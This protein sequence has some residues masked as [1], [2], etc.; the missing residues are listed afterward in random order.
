MVYLIF[1][2]LSLNYFIHFHRSYP[3]CAHL[4]S[5]HSTN[6]FAFMGRN[7]QPVGNGVYVLPMWPLRFTTYPQNLTNVELYI[8]VLSNVITLTIILTQKF[9]SIVQPIWNAFK[10]FQHI[11]MS[12]IVHINEVLYANFIISYFYFIDFRIEIIEQ[13][14]KCTYV[15]MRLWQHDFTT[16]KKKK[17]HFELKFFPAFKKNEAKIYFPLLKNFRMAYKKIFFFFDAWK[18]SLN[19]STHRNYL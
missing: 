7:S 13:T 17:C 9:P 14:D 10:N 16:S 8:Y 11:R 5:G 6:G 19:D 2:G 3:L 12:Y 1:R 15:D 18:F 4:I